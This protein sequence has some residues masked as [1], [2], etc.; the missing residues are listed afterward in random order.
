MAVDDVYSVDIHMTYQQNPNIMCFNYRVKVETDPTI[1]ISD[2][3]T[4]GDTTIKAA[5]LPLHVT[6]VLFPCVT[7]RQ[8]WPNNSLPEIKATAAIVGTRTPT[9]ALPGQCSN[10][11]TLFSDKLNPT[12]R[13]RGRDFWFGQDCADLVANGANYD[14]AWLDAV[15]AFYVALDQDFSG[16]GGAND[17]EWCIFSRTQAVENVDPQFVSNGGAVPDPPTFGNEPAPTVIFVRS[18]GLVRTQRRRQPEDPC[19]EFTE[20]DVPVSA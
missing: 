16:A 18:D 20:D 8:I 9:T 19:A 3:I 15:A 5:L 6:T 13:N 17:F 10:V 14:Q 7:V 1:V 4:Q 2:L 12:A 11:W